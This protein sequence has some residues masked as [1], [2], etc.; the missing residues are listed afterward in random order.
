MNKLFFAIYLLLGAVACKNG[1]SK[2]ERA[3][4]IHM[5]SAAPQKLAPTVAVVNDT[6]I[7]MHFSQTDTGVIAS[8][9]SYMNG[10][11]HVICEVSVSKADSIIGQV[12]PKGEN[13][14]VR[15]SQIILPNGKMDGPFGSRLSYA[16]PQTGTYKLIIGENM[17]AGDKWK[18]KFRLKVWV[19]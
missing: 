17:M 15:F 11:D 19:K 13:G 5:D 6:L 7:R 16:T 1:N 9:Q 18:G 4:I 8:T 14:N 12:S 2:T 3:T 10:D